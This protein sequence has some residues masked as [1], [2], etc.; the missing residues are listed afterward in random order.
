M[1]QMTGE[2]MRPFFFSFLEVLS[3]GILVLDGCSEW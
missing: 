2:T 1:V 3:K